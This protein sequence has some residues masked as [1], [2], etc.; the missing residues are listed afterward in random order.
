VT[1]TIS[2]LPQ[3]VTLQ[4]YAGDDFAMN[5]TVTNPDGSDFYLSS[6]TPSAQVRSRPRDA[7]PPLA[8]FGCSVAGNVL[9]L[10]LAGAVTA[11]LPGG[12]VY[13]V[14]LTGPQGQVMTLL[15]GTIAVVAEVTR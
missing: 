4:L 12:C 2:D 14:Q 11:T 7:D 8:E 1:T 15:C 13:D 3:T 6:W 5:V 10:A 9:T